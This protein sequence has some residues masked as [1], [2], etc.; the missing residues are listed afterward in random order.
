M[1]EVPRLG[2]ADMNRD[3]ERASEDKEEGADL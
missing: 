2:V 1:Q 3:R